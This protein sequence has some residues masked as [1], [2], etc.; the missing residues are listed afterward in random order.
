MMYTTSAT[1]MTTFLAFYTIHFLNYPSRTLIFEFDSIGTIFTKQGMHSFLF[2][3]YYLLKK[4]VGRKSL[5]QISTAEP[6]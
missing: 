4:K 6:L 3:V 2:N 5:C 1:Y